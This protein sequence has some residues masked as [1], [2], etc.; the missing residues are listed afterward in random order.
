MFALVAMTN[1]EMQRLWNGSDE[2]DRSTLA[3]TFHCFEQR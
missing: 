2:L 1:V 3:A